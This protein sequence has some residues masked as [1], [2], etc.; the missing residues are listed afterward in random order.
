MFNLQGCSRPVV[1]RRPPVP[2]GRQDRCTKQE[3]VPLRTTLDIDDDLMATVKEV[4]RCERISAG[5]LVSRLL[6]QSLT[7][8]QEPVAKEAG[9]KRAVAGFK[10]FSARAGVIVTNEE[11]NALRRAEG[12]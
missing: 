6:R 10:P 4:A 9:R 3:G 2:G 8:G 12:I 7:S 1:D 11:V 5:K